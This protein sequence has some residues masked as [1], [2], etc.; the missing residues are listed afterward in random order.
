MNYE[1][2]GIWQQ[3]VTGIREHY[4]VGKSRKS[5]NFSQKI[6]LKQW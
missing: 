6:G 2:I 4:Y 3:Y 5:I 1:S